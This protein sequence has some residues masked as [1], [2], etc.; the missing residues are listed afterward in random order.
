MDVLMFNPAPRRGW[1]AQR[2]V[3]LPLSL[4]APATPLDRQGYRVKI[5]DQYADPN[6]KDAF[7]DSLKQKPICFGV[8]CM[9]GP[10]IRR[11]LEVSRLFKERHPDVP[12][13][14]GGIHASLLPE[15][16]LANPYV[17]IVVVGEG[18]STF[19][20]LVKA[21]AAGGPL[22]RV[23]GICYKEGDEALGAV[24]KAGTDGSL[25]L[26]VLGTRQKKEPFTSGNSGNHAV[27]WTGERPFVNL[28]EQPPLSYHLVDMGLY[29]R[30]LFG[31]A[32]FSINTS[33]GCVFRC[34]FCWDPV[35]HKR[36]WRAM[37]PET[38]L[39]HLTAIVRDYG[40]QGFNFTDDHFFIDMKRA[41]AIMEGIVRSG[42]KITIGKL[43][44]RADTICR[45]DDD[46][47]KLIVRA[48]VKRF[49][50]GVESGSQ[51]LLDLIQ[52]DVK[53]EQVAEASR[54]LIPYPIVPL[55]L[56]MMGL[57][58]ETP[59]DLAAT[60]RLAE[61][62]VKE[63]PRACKTCNIYT[64]YPGTALYDL[65]VQLGLREPRRLEEWAAFNFRKV[66]DHSPWISAEM[67]RLV[68]RLDFPLMFLGNH[69]IMP[70]KRT[71]PLVVPLA[72]L[73]RPVARYRIKKLETRFPIETHL[74][75]AMGLFAR[76]D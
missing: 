20:E 57:P 4:L 70:Y 32:H 2:R 63:N 44:V 72:R 5:I 12:V 75:K 30:H 46:F 33:R 16:T 1:Q 66:A 50:I 74:V 52:K 49:T 42:L 6:W 35:L 19:E 39:G 56:F 60:I 29:R 62:L 43:Q 73:Y 8:T 53:L 14:W 23:Q 10:Q 68:A 26:R 17:D 31:G 11:A 22:S 9:T 48:G 64:P 18:E 25:G 34:K 41:Y 76:Q 3:E 69:F 61:R 37:K 65:A 47:L 67:R 38:V 27:H 24:G 45:M 36:R 21:L 59:E 58:T 28:D 15:Q 51:R 7:R 13:V 54:K 55:Y 40:I 71:N